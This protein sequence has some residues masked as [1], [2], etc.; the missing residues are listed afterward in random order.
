MPLPPAAIE[1]LHRWRADH[2]AALLARI[3]ALI[4][5]G[6]DVTPEPWID[7]PPDPSA[8]RGAPQGPPP[9]EGGAPRPAQGADPRRPKDDP[10]RPAGADD[11]RRPAG[12]QDARPGAGGGSGRPTDGSPPAGGGGARRSAD[13]Q[14]AR[15]PAGSHAARHSART[16]AARLPPRGGGLRLPARRD[17]A[18][19]MPGAAPVLEDLPAPPP[20]GGPAAALRLAGGAALELRPFRWQRAALSLTPWRGRALDWRPLRRWALEHMAPRMGDAAPELAGVIHRVGGPRSAKGARILTLDLGSAPAQAALAL[21]EAAQ[22]AGA[23]RIALG[24]P[25]AWPEG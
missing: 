10:R 4:E 19:A 5:A 15:R 20:P 11:P 24:P 14:D 16:H 22:A 9:Q 21:I 12:G 8:A 18:W 13:G 1:D 25:G 3:A 6:A 23:A 7:A 2:V 17:L